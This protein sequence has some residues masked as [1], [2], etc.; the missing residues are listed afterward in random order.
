[1]RKIKLFILLLIGISFMLSCGKPNDAESVPIPDISG[2]YTIV[3]KFITAGYSQDVLK[4]DNLLYM[5]QGEGGLQIIDITNPEDP[6]TDRT[7]Y[8]VLQQ[9]HT[10][11]YHKRPY[12]QIRSR[13]FL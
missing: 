11:A 2:G 1:M 7:V 13:H 3:K 12:W 6:Q 5:A 8:Q 10:R 9:G 4:K